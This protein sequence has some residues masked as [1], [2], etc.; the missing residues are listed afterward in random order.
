M[1][2]LQT[3]MANKD[4]R[5]VPLASNCVGFSLL[6]RRRQPIVGEDGWRFALQKKGQRGGEMKDSGAG[7]EKQRASI[8][9]GNL[10][11]KR[12][13]NR[14]S[15]LRGVHAGSFFPRRYRRHPD[16]CPY[17]WS[18]VRHTTKHRPVAAVR[19]GRLYPSPVRRR[20]RRHRN[21]RGRRRRRRRCRPHQLRHGRPRRRRC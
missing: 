20:R 17:P 5:P 1:Q 6:S 7:R 16:I 8:F 13:Q 15:H 10:R 9:I 19:R 3:D 21:R 4:F 14:A 11:N 12:A 2:T 18:V